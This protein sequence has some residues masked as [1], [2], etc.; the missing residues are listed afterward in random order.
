MNGKTRESKALTKSTREVELPD[1]ME[2]RGFQVTISNF[3]H[4]LE[5]P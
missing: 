5:E 1:G 2:Y 3:N 4:L